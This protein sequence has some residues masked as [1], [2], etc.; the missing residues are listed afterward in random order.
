M[1]D[2]EK[3][4]L[5]SLLRGHQLVFPVEVYGMV[6][7]DPNDFS[8]E[9]F[10]LIGCWLHDLGYKRKTRPHFRHATLMSIWVREE[11]WP[12]ETP[13]DRKP[14]AGIRLK[15]DPELFESR[16]DRRER[17]REWQRTLNSFS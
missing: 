10:V 5:R 1:T 2:K 4:A 11:T 15:P 6:G 7:G 8:L 12:G 9:E 17:R 13:E 3:E 16:A 14:Y